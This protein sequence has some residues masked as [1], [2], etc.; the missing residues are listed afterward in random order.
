MKRIFISTMTLV[1]LSSAGFAQ[2]KD[3]FGMYWDMNV[4]TNGNYLT[5]MSFAGMKFEYRH[6][7]KYNFSAGLATNWYSYSQYFN[8]Q[9]YTK[10]DGSYAVTSDF[11]AHVYTLP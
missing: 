6:F 5:K 11:V 1:L 4:P 10:Q 3:V 7:F 9:T 2:K 8:R